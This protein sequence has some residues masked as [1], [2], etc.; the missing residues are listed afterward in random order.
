MGKRFISAMFM[1]P[2]LILLVLR[3]VPL[4]IGG[5]ILMSIGLHEFYTAFENKGYKPIKELGYLYT[6][7]IFIGN[8]LKWGTEGYSFGFFIVFILSILYVLAQKRDVMDVSLTISGIMYI[9]LCFNYIIM[10]VD[11]I[12]AGHLYVYLIFII[13]FSTDIFAYLVGKQFGK[14]KLIPKVSPNKTVEGSLGG[15]AAS[16]VFSVLFGIAFNLQIG[17]L[18]FVALI[19]SVVAQLGDL[20]ASSIKRYVGIKDFGKIIPGHG[21]VLDRFDS[22]LLVSPYV[23]LVLFYFIK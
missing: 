19:G 6:I 20:I 3:G 10:T 1:V 16:V 23:Y 15:I 9:C 7:I 18:V 22:V 11:N 13:A 5:V 4:Y 2:L 17:V 21:G 12:A 14:H 8:Y